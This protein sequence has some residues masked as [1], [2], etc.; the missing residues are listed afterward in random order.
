MKLLLLTLIALLL[1]FYTY[2]SYTLQN[3]LISLVLG[4]GWGVLLALTLIYIIRLHK[5]LATLE[6]E[7]RKKFINLI[8]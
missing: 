6:A 8:K 5:T 7:R 1:L 2:L 4:Y 3:V